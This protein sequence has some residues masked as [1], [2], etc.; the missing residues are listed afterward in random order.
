[1][2]FWSRFDAIAREHDVLRH[3]FYVRWSVGELSVAELAD[4]AGQY[5]HAVVALAEASASAAASADGAMGRELAAHAAEEAE[6]IELWDRFVDAVGGERAAT[7][8]RNTA[9]CA[10]AWS[11]AGGRGLLGTLVAL[12]AIESA[13]P[14]IS[15]TKRDGLA[16]HYGIDGPPAAYFELHERLDVVHASAGRK[17]I[18]ARLADADHERLLGEAEVVLRSNWELLDG[19]ERSLSHA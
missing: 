18:D 1:M 3:R 7:P 9:A 14:Q 19:V 15:K 5:R 17:L 11:G 8:N 4:Y 12:Y 2:E 10:S 13:Q 16:T 6:H